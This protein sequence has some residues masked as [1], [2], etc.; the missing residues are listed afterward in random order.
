MTPPG[1][2]SIDDVAAPFENYLV[3]M[4][5]PA[6]DV[7]ATCHSSKFSSDFTSCFPCNEAGRR[8]HQICA[9][10]VAS[11]ALA[12]SNEQLARDLYAYKDARLASAVRRPLVVGLAAVLYKWLHHHEDCL[13]GAAGVTGGSFDILTSVPSTGGRSGRHPLVTLLTEVVA[14]SEERYGE[15]LE[16]NRTDLGPRDFAPDRFVAMGAVTGTVLLVDDSWVTGAKPQAAAAAL[17]AAGAERV[18]VLTIGRWF[19]LGYERNTDWLKEKRKPGWRW[20]TC[21]LH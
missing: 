16:V 5:A 6:T 2:R 8:L 4:P 19:N 10:A 20:D 17:K 14:G 1:S 21:C 13:A 9:D 18:A 11:V 15:L 12:P 7:C 3:P